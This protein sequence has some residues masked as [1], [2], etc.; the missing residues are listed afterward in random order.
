MITTSP[1]N[2]ECAVITKTVFCATSHVP[3]WEA[4]KRQRVNQET[5]GLPKHFIIQQ[6]QAKKPTNIQNDIR[7]NIPTAISPS[8]CYFFTFSNIS[9]YYFITI[10]NSYWFIHF[11]SYWIFFTGH[12]DWSLSLSLWLLCCVLR[13]KEIQCRNPMQNVWLNIQ[14]VQK[15]ETATSQ[16][17]KKAS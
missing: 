6:L 2:V 12:R 8:K 7:N 16:K 4:N 14:R 10:S 3:D 15:K 1:L 13:G 9:K 11:M 5:L 17:L